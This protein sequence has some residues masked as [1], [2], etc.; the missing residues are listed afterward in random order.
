MSWQWGGLKAGWMVSPPMWGSAAQSFS[1]VLLDGN[2]WD[3]FYLVSSLMKKIFLAVNRMLA[4]RLP[5]L[6]Q[7]DPRAGK[8]CIKGCFLG[9]FALNLTQIS[10]LVIYFVYSFQIFHFSFLKLNDNVYTYI[11]S[12]F[13]SEFFES[14][15]HRKLVLVPLCP[16]VI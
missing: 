6:L 10:C 7:L 16:S 9:L 4:E 2:Y 1:E 13:F 3:W 14:V 8:L 15:C 5:S 11:M 12:L